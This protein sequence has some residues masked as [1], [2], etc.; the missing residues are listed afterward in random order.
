MKPFIL[1]LHVFFFCSI[2]LFAQS[3]EK[4]IEG[5]WY[6]EDISQSIIMIFKDHKGTLSGKIIKSSDTTL[7]NNDPLTGFRYFPDKKM[8]VGKVKPAN[9][10]FEIDGEISIINKSTLKLVGSRFFITKTFLLK[11]I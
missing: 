7:V 11:R 4:S 9:R 2:S 8:Y 1:F 6:A 10:N 5:N 3:P